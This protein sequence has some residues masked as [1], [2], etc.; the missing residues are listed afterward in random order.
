[1]GKPGS[2]VCRC[3]KSRVA[4]T[5]SA[6]SCRYK[7]FVG[8]DQ[9]FDN[10]FGVDVGYLGSGREFYEQTLTIFSGLFFTLA[11]GAVFGFEIFLE[12]KLIQG[13]FS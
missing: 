4:L 3:F 13:P 11:M 2:P 10:L 6:A 12:S 7:G 1:M 5:A 8:F 9:V